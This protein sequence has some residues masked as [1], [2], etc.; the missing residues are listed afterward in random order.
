MSDHRTYTDLDAFRLDDGRVMVRLNEPGHRLPEEFVPVAE[1][2]AYKAALEA[3]VE[4]S[5]EFFRPNS[6]GAPLWPRTVDA[7]SVLAGE[8]STTEE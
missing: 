7:R 6:L 4:A 8:S 5:E 3:L 1:R 2:D